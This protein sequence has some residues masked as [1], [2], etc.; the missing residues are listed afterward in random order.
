MKIFIAVTI[1]L[2]ANNLN[3]VVAKQ[4]T[5]REYRSTKHLVTSLPGLNPFPNDYEMYTGYLDIDGT[6]K[7][8]KE[9]SLFY[10]F[11]ECADNSSNNLIVWFN[12]CS[13]CSSLYALLKENGPFIL[14]ESNTTFKE[15]L[16]SWNKLSHVLYIDSPS[17]TGFSPK[18]DGV[19]NNHKVTQES[20][21]AIYQFFDL[22]PRFQSC[23]IFLSG[24]SYS[25]II[26]PNIVNYARRRYQDLY[27]KL[28][29][30]VLLSP[31]L[32]WKDNLKNMADYA[33][34]HGIISVEMYQSL[35]SNGCLEKFNKLKNKQAESTIEQF[36]HNAIME[37]LEF[38]FTSGLNVNNIVK[39]C[40]NVA[41]IIQKPFEF[42]ESLKKGSSES[43][44]NY[45]PIE[46]YM[47]R[48][49]VREA[50]GVDTSITWQACGT[51]PMVNE[52]SPDS[53]R[54][55]RRM[56]YKNFKTMMI[57]GD[58]ALLNNFL[59]GDF[60]WEDIA[61][62]TEHASREFWYTKPEPGKEFQVGGFT[63]YKDGMSLFSIKGSG[64]KVCEDAPRSVFRFVEDFIR[65]SKI[66]DDKEY[67]DE[68]L[69][70]QTDYTTV[71]K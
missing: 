22:F 35:D 36:C 8:G 60:F 16:Q 29:G 38:V 67:E 6:N 5:S 9:G 44:S 20:I 12:G 7:P 46:R 1:L 65:T 27:S 28:K 68:R 21:K 63:K 19:F 59:H 3:P 33:L 52:S 2:L 10:W 56:I 53:R 30:V 14:N 50:I 69:K 26:I 45:D 34:Y 15:N 54:N 24:E 43:C 57:Y 49:D 25:G 42:S 18:N 31:F 71:P 11:V 55:F 61:L 70:L 47:N 4:R 51:H 17:E 40:H 64:N 58:Q 66:T 41:S 39:K 48:N 37:F 13:G 32:T 23:D 62:D